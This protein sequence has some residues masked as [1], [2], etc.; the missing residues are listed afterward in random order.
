M[1]N[2]QSD[3]RWV[4]IKIDRVLCNEAWEVYYPEVETVFL[5]EGNFDHS[6]M[7]VQFFKQILRTTHFKFCN[8][9]ATKDMFLDVVKGVWAADLTGYKSYQVHV[10][11]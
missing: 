9:W 3:D 5:P 4:L 7:I 8:F 6:P 1:E 2:K 11:L 10:R